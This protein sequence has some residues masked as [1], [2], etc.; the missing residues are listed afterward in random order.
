[1][2]P[3]SRRP[4]ID[5]VICCARIPPDF[6]GCSLQS[7]IFFDFGDLLV[8]AADC[9]D[10]VGLRGLADVDADCVVAVKVSTASA[11]RLVID[12]IGNVFELQSATVRGELLDI[13]QAANHASRDGFIP[14][15]TVF[16]LTQRDVQVRAIETAE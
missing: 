12:D 3:A 8:D 16:D 6:D 15:V 4:L 11:H 1:M 13:I 9:L 5:L 2:T 10:R 14:A 7:G